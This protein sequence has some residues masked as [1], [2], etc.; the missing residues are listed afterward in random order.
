MIFSFIQILV[1]SPASWTGNQRVLLHRCTN[2]VFPECVDI[3]GLLGRPG[4]P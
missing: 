1:E 3:L 2:L 4:R